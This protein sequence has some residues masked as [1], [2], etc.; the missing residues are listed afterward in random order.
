MQL[1][2]IQGAQTSGMVEVRVEEVSKEGE[3]QEKA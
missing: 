1:D 3:K 2:V